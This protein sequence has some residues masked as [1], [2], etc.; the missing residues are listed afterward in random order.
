[1]KRLFRRFFR[2]DR[3]DML[4]GALTM[5]IIILATL[6][7]VN[8]SIAGYASTTAINAANYGARLGSVDQ[9]NP[10]GAALAGAQRS[11]RAGIGRYH[12]RVFASTAPGSTVYVMVYWQ[13]PNFF[14]PLMPLFGQS[15]RPLHG[16]AISTFRKE[17]W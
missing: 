9:T 7:L 13:V 16:M 14:G 1:M 12:V 10:V 5:P 8:L 6:A 4:E 17:G 2:D 3:G 11:L 15:N